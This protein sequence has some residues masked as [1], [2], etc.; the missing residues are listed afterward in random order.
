M[1]ALLYIGL[2]STRLFVLM[3]QG[4]E[5]FERSGSHPNIANTASAVGDNVTESERESVP[6][7]SAAD[8]PILAPQR[9]SFRGNPAGSHPILGH[10]SV[11]CVVCLQQQ[12]MKIERRNL[13]IYMLS[14]SYPV[15][16]RLKFAWH[17]KHTRRKNQL[18]RKNFEILN[19]DTIFRLIFK[20]I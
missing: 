3:Y 18:V 19:E 11:L 20:E 14:C 6:T 13:I 2:A 9:L 7:F 16:T 4:I 15:E 10:T 12:K 17:P 8:A 5:N 1:D